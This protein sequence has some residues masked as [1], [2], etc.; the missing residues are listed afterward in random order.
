MYY[1]FEIHGNVNHELSSIVVDMGDTLKHE[2][3]FAAYKWAVHRAMAVLSTDE[4][5]KAWFTK[6]LSSS[7]SVKIKNFRIHSP[8]SNGWIKP[9]TQGY[10]YTGVDHPVCIAKS[11][12][13]SLAKL[14]LLKDKFEQ[15][16]TKCREILKKSNVLYAETLDKTPVEKVFRPHV[17]G[18]LI[19]SHIY[20]VGD[21]IEYC[22]ER[23]LNEIHG[24]G[25]EIAIEISDC[26]MQY[27]Q[28]KAANLID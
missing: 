9:N 21:L 2:V 19:H 7:F 14:K 28:R 20:N 16:I 22:K 10:F 12:K 15:E 17:S 11:D 23:Q 6:Q 5:K 13:E 26:L 3:I 1:Q 27:R 8:Q 24:V 25:P 18:T 4:H